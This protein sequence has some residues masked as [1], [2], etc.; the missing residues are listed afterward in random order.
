MKATIVDTRAG[1]ITLGV[2]LVLFGL[3][4]DSSGSWVSQAFHHVAIL[5]GGI[6]LGAA[7]KK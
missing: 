6:S 7:I 4:L 1:K 2:L 5:C 3:V